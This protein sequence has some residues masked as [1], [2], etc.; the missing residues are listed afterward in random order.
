MNGWVA[1]DAQVLFLAL[2]TML[3]IAGYGIKWLPLHL[4][5]KDGRVR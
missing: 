3:H 5:A 4:P 2:S 1:V